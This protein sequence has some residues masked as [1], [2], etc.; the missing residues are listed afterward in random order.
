M[1]ITQNRR[2]L[3]RT[4]DLVRL[5]LAGL[6]IL[7]NA[8]PAHA[9]KSA[10]EEL[11]SIHASKAGVDAKNNFWAWD[12]Q[13]G[14]VTRITPNGDRIESDIVPDGWTVDADPKRGIAILSEDGRIIDI[15]DWSGSKKHSIHLLHKA[16]DVAWLSGTHI[17]VT[18]QTT[19]PCV[20]IWDASTGEYLSG[21]GKC[22]DIVPPVPGMVVARATLLRYDPTHREIVTF[23]AFRTD[24]SAFSES[25]SLT[26]HSHV[27]HSTTPEFDA[28]LKKIDAKAKAQGGS[29]TEIIFWYPSITIAPDRS[30]WLG[31][32]ADSK[33]ITAVTI[34]Q[35]GTV[36]RARIDVPQ[37]P[38]NRMI[39]WND[40]L[41]FYRDPRYPQPL[42]STVR[43]RK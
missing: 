12:K 23:D 10:A 33:G 37:C 5:G 26:R 40:D 9:R 2:E 39:A 31:Q 3:I 22:P 36:Q 7:T 42:C 34:L 6:V 32:D 25:G 18:P 8:W 16:T 43:R 17:A 14:V 13:R 21:F 41:V 11:A 28:W 30:V 29:S 1:H 4:N 35:D 24:L 38:S 20:E 19:G 15:V 27:P